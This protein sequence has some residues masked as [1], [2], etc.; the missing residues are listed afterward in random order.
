MQERKSEHRNDLDWLRVLSILVVFIF[1]CG[2][3]FDTDGWHVKNPV[4]H[5]AVMVWTGFLVS[6]M[7]P[8]MFLISGASIWYA[9]KSKGAGVFIRDRALRL[10]VPLVVGIFSHI[11]LQVYLER[12][13]FSGF[14]GSFFRFYPVYFHGWYGFGGNF[15]WMGLHLWYLLVLFVYSLLFYPLFS[16]LRAGLGKRPLEV[17]SGFLALPGAMYLLG[18]PVAILL[19]VLNPREFTGMRDFGGWPLIVYVL[20]FLYGFII[21]SHDGLQMRIQQFRWVSLAAGILCISSLL[22][23]WASQGDPAFGSS[24]YL[25]VFGI[26]GL[27][28]WC[29]I[30]AFFG[31]GFRHFTQNKPILAYASEA[32]LPFY[33]LHQTILLSVGYYVTR[34]AIPD[35]V[36]FFSISLSSFII[37][38]LL[39]EF[40]IRRSNF[41][42]FLFGMK[43]VLKAQLKRSFLPNQIAAAKE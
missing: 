3:F 2:R 43:P 27:S 39:Y 26:Y 13:S 31:F 33:I 10:L 6:W 34:W 21:V 23:L 40:L 8:L 7:M 15:A 18:L 5:E 30:L 17:F 35:P 25:Q 14:E 36:K 11:A 42:R 41:L 9:L 12:R 38:M 4:R 29:W 32:V 24:R 20:F 19:V 1:H 37:T 16:W 22:V 28:S